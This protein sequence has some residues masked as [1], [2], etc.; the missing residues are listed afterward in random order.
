MTR[1]EEEENREEPASWWRCCP[2]PAI[3]CEPRLILHEVPGAMALWRQPGNC[4]AS[5][6]GQSLCVKHAP[7]HLLPG[8]RGEWRSCVRPLGS[9]RLRVEIRQV[10]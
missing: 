1:E 6:G 5:Q 2:L 10:L 3:C 7:E 9:E 4:W 8:K